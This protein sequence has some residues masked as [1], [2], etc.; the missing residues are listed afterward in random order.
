MAL[1]PDVFSE[2]LTGLL[3]L[4]AV[5]RAYTAQTQNDRRALL[6]AG[7]MAGLLIATRIAAVIAL[8]F[9]ALYVAMVAWSHQS[10]DLDGVS[11]GV[12][13]RLCT[14]AMRLGLWG[15]G[16]VP[17]VTLVIGYNLARFGMPLA[18]GYGDEASAFT[19]RC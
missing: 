7:V 13:T 9:L 11:I 19:T 2:P 15:L 18:S 12:V 10:P 3:L 17:G 6:A 4:C 8:P 1:C 5:E 14:V 16:L